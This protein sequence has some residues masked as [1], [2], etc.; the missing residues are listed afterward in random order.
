MKINETREANVN[1]GHV[2]EET[3]NATSKKGLELLIFEGVSNSLDAQAGEINIAL[4]DNELVIRDDGPGMNRKDFDKAFDVGVKSKEQQIGI[5]HLGQGMKSGLLEARKARLSTK[6][7]DFSGSCQFYTKERGKT[8]EIKRDDEDTFLNQVSTGTKLTYILRPKLQKEATPQRIMSI[9]QKWFPTLLDNDFINFYKDNG[10]RDRKELYPDGTQ[11]Y[12]NGRLVPQQDL[13]N[14]IPIDKVTE[15]NI[16]RNYGHGERIIGYYKLA[17]S[18]KKLENH[19]IYRIVCGMKINRASNLGNYAVAN[20][21]KIIGYIEYIPLVE[22]LKSNKESFN[23]DG[24]HYKS[25]FPNDFSNSIYKNFLKKEDLLRGAQSDD[26][27][28]DTW[29]K[30]SQVFPKGLDLPPGFASGNVTNTTDT[31]RENKIEKKKGTPKKKSRL[32]VGGKRPKIQY[33]NDPQGVI[34]TVEK[35]PEGIPYI[36]INKAHD[37]REIDPSELQNLLGIL[38]A[39]IEYNLDNGLRDDPDYILEAFDDGLKRYARA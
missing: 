37:M 16:T 9:V 10:F 31:G 13:F 36:A 27:L 34:A 35:F 11:F 12:I 28:A 32:T 39:S 23:R 1:V 17:K 29:K 5:G 18:H 25:Y 21:E 38:Y 4:D 20:R 2:L 6:S 3:V 15:G 24:T 22:D 8:V 26:E 19:G 33:I 7:K 14:N 30:F